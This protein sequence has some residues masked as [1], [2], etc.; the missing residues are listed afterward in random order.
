MRER[1]KLSGLFWKEEVLEIT[2]R[3]EVGK[4]WRKISSTESGISRL[5]SEQT[6][7]TSRLMWGRPRG[8]VLFIAEFK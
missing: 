5:I 8:V 4:A 2:A 7:F 6:D 1:E 3:E